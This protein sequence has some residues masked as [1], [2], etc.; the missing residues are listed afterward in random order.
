MSLRL[1][2]GCV[3]TLLLFQNVPNNFFASTFIRLHYQTKY[4]TIPTISFS[5]YDT[6]NLSLPWLLRLGRTGL[7]KTGE[8]KSAMAAEG[9]KLL[10]KEAADV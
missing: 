2:K 8:R 10:L 9:A 4:G 1:S 5:L 6:G 7:S 3:T